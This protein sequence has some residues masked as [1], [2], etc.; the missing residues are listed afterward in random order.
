MKVLITEPA[1]KDIGAIREYLAEKYPHV[2]LS[3]ERRLRLSLARIATWPEGAQ[4]VAERPNVRVVPLVRYPYKIFYRLRR[5][6]VEIL[7]V[8]HSSRS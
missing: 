2:L 6:A 8:H 4:K 1:L 7:H 5:G 3:V